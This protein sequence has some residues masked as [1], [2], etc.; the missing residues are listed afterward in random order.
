[1][2]FDAWKDNEKEIEYFKTLMGKRIGKVNIIIEQGYKI[3][4]DVLG[5]VLNGLQFSKMEIFANRLSDEAM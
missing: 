2:N 3:E 1:M 4:M 5:K